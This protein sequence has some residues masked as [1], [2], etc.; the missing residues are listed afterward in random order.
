MKP[1]IAK[2]EKEEG[3][4]VDS[5]EVWHNEDNAKKLEEYDQDLCGGVP[6]FYNTKNKKF[7]CGEASYEE[8]KDW[9]EGTGSAKD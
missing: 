5:Y 7:I 1:L 9:A 6:F 4:K 8:L 2:L 3:V